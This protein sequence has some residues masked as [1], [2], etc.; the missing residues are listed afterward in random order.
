MRILTD[1]YINIYIYVYMH[2]DTQ[3]IFILVI[4]SLKTKRLHKGVI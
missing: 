4:Y 2:T 1:R 3:N